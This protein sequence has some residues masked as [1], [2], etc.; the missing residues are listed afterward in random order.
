MR[1][2]LFRL[3]ALFQPAT[4]RDERGMATYLTALF[5]GAGLLFTMV[6]FIQFTNEFGTRQVSQN[7]SDA[8]SLAAAGFYADGLSI[9]Y[10]VPPLVGFCDEP[11]RSVHKRAV[12]M[13][14]GYYRG[15]IGAGRGGAMA[16]AAHFA[17]RNTT[18]VDRFSSSIT[19][20]WPEFNYT[21]RYTGSIFPPTLVKLRTLRPYESRSGQTHD[22]P[23]YASA[24]AYLKRMGTTV[25]YSFTDGTCLYWVV[26]YEYAWKVSLVDDDR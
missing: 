12:A 18:S 2:L 26:Q 24:V 21:H 17:R 16:E 10:P 23:A 14:Q 1:T 8:A 7:G 9:K 13:Y 3:H 5:A 19:G 6:I 22:V 4:W 15:F 11:R 20:R 25:D